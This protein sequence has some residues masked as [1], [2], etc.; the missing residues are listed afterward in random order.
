MSNELS[1]A[2]DW[3]ANSRKAYCRYITA[4]FQE[5]N[6]LFTDDDIGNLLVVGVMADGTLTGCMLLHDE[7]IEVFLAYY[8]INMLDEQAVIKG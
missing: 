8:N 6:I 5:D 4:P 3:V 1:R 7:D 2:I